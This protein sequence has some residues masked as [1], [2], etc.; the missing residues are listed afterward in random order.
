MLL[1]K[2]KAAG[3]RRASISM[4]AA[5]A[6][7]HRRK[8]TIERKTANNVSESFCV[9]LNAAGAVKER[10]LRCL[11]RVLVYGLSSRRAAKRRWRRPARMPAWRHL[12]QR[13][14]NSSMHRAR[15]T[16]G[17][18]RRQPP[19]A[20]LAGGGMDRADL[21]A[22]AASAGGRRRSAIAVAKGAAPAWK[23]KRHELTFAR[24]QSALR[25]CVFSAHLLRTAAHACSISRTVRV[26]CWAQR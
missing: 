19:G 21:S 1:A 6:D 9:L 12:Q 20:T 2:A 7:K 14:L 23:K 18:K 25:S 22:Q 16:C 17:S 8:R 26:V 11:R 10:S 5:A 3:H 13:I 24:F 15:Q 4:Q